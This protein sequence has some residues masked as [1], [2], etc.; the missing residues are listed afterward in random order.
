MAI[1][2]ARATF[3]H[4]ILGIY[5]KFLGWMLLF[6]VNQA[7]KALDCLLQRSFHV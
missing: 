3:E 6:K 2:E 4:H 1:F 5:V 7:H